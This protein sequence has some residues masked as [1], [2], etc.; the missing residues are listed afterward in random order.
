M[1]RI[2]PKET[3]T[4]ELEE[5][6]LLPPD[7]EIMFRNVMRPHGM[8]LITGPTGCGKSTTLYAMLTRLGAEKKYVVNI[9]TVEDPVECNVSRISQV[10]LNPAAGLTFPSALRS[11]LR[12]DPDII[13]VGEIRDRDTAEMAVRAALIGRLLLSPLHTNDATGAVARMLDIGVEAYLLASTLT[14]VVGQRLVRRLCTN[15]RETIAPNPS[16][17][18][19]LKSRPDFSASI[20]ALQAQN[21]LGKGDDPLTGM[22]LFKAKGCA[23]C[24]GSGFRGRIGIFELFEI[25]DQTRN[26]ILERRD[27]SSI[28][29][30]AIAGGMKSLFQDGLG[31]AFLGHTTLEEVTRAAL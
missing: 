25:S 1:I 27:V 3:I 5:L 21:F 31:K 14:L 8:I 24:H 19:S 9:S 29:A 17:I 4:L 18:E 12:Q 13:M 7:Y 15:C 10:T 11:M 16:V 22:R 30:A 2:H 26:M 6:G 20:H 28:R 23:Q